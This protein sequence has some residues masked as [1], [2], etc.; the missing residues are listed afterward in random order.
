M[1][2]RIYMFIYMYTDVSVIAYTLALPQMISV[3]VQGPFICMPSP[4]SSR[5][6]QRRSTSV[7]ISLAYTWYIAAVPCLRVPIVLPLSMWSSGPE[8]TNAAQGSSPDL[9]P[10]PWLEPDGFHGYKNIYI[11]IYTCIHMYIYTC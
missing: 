1:H 9:Q 10:D 3:I 2:V 7:L 11:Y 5:H 8:S 6:L 4:A